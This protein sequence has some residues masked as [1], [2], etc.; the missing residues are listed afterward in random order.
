M[1]IYEYVCP[2]C[3]VEFEVMRPMSEASKVAVCPRCGSE[4]Q[5][6]L[7]G[8]ASKTGSYVQSPG[9]SFRQPLV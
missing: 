2:K 8:F 3:K 9:K 1:A 4:G 6:L 5:R 7:S